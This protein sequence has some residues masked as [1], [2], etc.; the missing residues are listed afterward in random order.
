M[1]QV[2]QLVKKFSIFTEGSLQNIAIGISP[3]GF[4]FILHHVSYVYVLDFSLQF[5]SSGTFSLLP[6]LS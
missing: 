1:V 4:P 6:L 2:T 5:L 3:E